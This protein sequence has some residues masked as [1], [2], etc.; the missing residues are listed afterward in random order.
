MAYKSKEWKKFRE[1]SVFSLPQGTHRVDEKIYLRV[2]GNCRTYFFRYTDENGKQKDCSL[3][4]AKNSS[5]REIKQKAAFFKS[6]YS[7]GINRAATKRKSENFKNF[8]ERTISVLA[9]VKRWKN[10]AQKASWQSTMSKYVY[11]KIGEKQIDE[12]SRKDVLDVL[13]PIWEKITATASKL[14]GR[15]ELIF[16]YAI[17]EGLYH[18][19]N[20]ASWKGNLEMNLPPVRKVRKEVHFSSIPHE[21]LKKV[22]HKVE[23]SKASGKAVLFGILTATRSCEFT[24]AQWKEIDFINKV[25][26]CPPSRRKDGKQEPFRVPL[27][28]QAIFLLKS[29]ERKG[30]Y[31]F[32]VT[33]KFPI[34]RET[35][36]Q[37][38]QSVFGKNYTMHGMRATFRDW[39][40]ENLIDYVLAEKSL[41]HSTGNNVVVAYQRSDLLEQRR[42]V[43]Q[44][45]AN[46]ICGEFCFGQ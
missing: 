31:I 23:L 22:I 13:E 38:V 39:C 7:F 25:W 43:M 17:A 27:S 33:G 35:A 15:L 21:E 44:Q 42:L 37:H 45:W 34:G 8:A 28:E 9:R 4:S 26:N 6:I 11:P 29:I 40:A 20:P 2:R 16:A 18:E 10:P 32:T 3:G 41:M 1:R 19:G 14:R 36:R 5:L 46:Y 30:C 12:I 24:Q